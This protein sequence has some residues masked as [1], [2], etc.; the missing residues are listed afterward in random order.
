MEPI[1]ESNQMKNFLGGSGFGDNK[2]SK[3]NELNESMSI[4]PQSP[5]EYENKIKNVTGGGE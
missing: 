1:N 3:D 2:L 5:D 4:K